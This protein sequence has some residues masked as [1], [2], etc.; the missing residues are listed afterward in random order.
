MSR[1]AKSVLIFGIYLGLIG[2]IF[3]I[4]PNL[5][6]TPFGIEPTHEVW[7]RLSGILLMAIAVYYIIAAK[8]ELVVIMKATAYI[9]FTI[10]LFFTAFALLGF[11]SSTIILFAV[12]DFLGGLWTLMMLKKEGHMGSGVS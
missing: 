5:L 7:I 11:V 3:L 9:R 2:I 6:L 8:H 4:V 1:S 10:I 12:V